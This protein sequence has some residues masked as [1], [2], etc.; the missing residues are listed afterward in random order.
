MNSNLEQSA[1]SMR[2][3]ERGRGEE[4]E[5]IANRKIYMS[6]VL[7]HSTLLERIVCSIFDIALPLARLS[8]LKR[9][10]RVPHASFNCIVLDS[11]V[12]LT[13]MEINFLGQWTTD[14]THLPFPMVNIFFHFSFS[15]QLAPMSVRL[16]K[17]RQSRASNRMSESR[18]NLIN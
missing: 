1:K 13:L 5:S 12:E 7:N 2:A 15:H 3:R 8:P 10:N 6:N 18:L 11:R 4:R 16:T 17:R 9:Q 14:A